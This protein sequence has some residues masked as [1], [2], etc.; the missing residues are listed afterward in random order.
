MGAYFMNAVPPAPTLADVSPFPVKT[1]FVDMRDISTAGKN[2]GEER[3]V[4]P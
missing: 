3:E 2:Y 4:L 1:H